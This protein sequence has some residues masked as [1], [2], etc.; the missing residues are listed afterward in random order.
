VVNRSSGR[1]FFAVF[2]AD[3]ASIAAFPSGPYLRT[4]ISFVGRDSRFGGS[5]STVKKIRAAGEKGQASVICGA[6]T[7]SEKSYGA[8][9][10]DGCGDCADARCGDPDDAGAS[11]SFAVCRSACAFAAD[12]TAA[13]GAFAERGWIDSHGSLLD[14]RQWGE[15]HKEG[16]GRLHAPGPAQEGS[17]PLL[18]KES[19]AESTTASS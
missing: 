10:C 1:R 6:A 2:L 14:E 18:R 13:D 15:D 11:F 19:A 7:A 9:F 17:R 5:F 3:A 4:E 12:G 8:S 16:V